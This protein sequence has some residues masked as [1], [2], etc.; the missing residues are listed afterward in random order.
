M[1]LFEDKTPV[2]PHRGPEQRKGKDRRSGNP[3]REEVRYEPAKDDRR[4]G[5]DRRKHEAWDDTPRR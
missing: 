5:K 2:S 1:T 4:S 3:R